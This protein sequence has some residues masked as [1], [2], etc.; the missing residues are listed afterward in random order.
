MFIAQPQPSPES[1]RIIEGTARDMGFEMNLTKAWAWRPDVFE[2]FVALRNGLTSKSSLSKRE[3]AVIVCAT[4]AELGD[5]YCALAWGH[6]LSQQAGP[7]VAAAVIAR[8]V[9]PT[10]TPRDRALA[11]WARQVVADPNGTTP[12]DVQALRQ[13]GLSELD[14]FEATAFIAFRLAFASVNDAL[15]VQP[16]RQ[17]KERLAPEVA[18]AIDFGRH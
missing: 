12:D 14:I 1:A 15:G 16:D 18:S 13:A 10:M 9:E 5:A 17:L 11:T 2:A 4:A 8:A 7:A 6:T 3:L